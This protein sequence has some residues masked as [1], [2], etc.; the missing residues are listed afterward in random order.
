[1][2][3]YIT[4]EPLALGLFNRTYTSGTGAYSQ[5]EEECRNN[6]EVLHLLVKR[7]HDDFS[8]LHTK[9]RKPYNFKELDNWL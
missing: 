8:A 2:G 1:M 7:M 4:H 6:P 9:F 3:R 5:W